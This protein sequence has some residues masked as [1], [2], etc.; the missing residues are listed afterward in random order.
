[1]RWLIACV[2]LI[3]SAGALA[4]GPVYG[5]LQVGMAGVRHSD[6]DF[7]PSFA[8]GSLGAFVIPNIGVELFGDASIASAEDG[9][10][11]MD[12]EQAYGVALRFQS[13]PKRGLS[14][15]V[16]VGAVNYTLNQQLDIEGS[17]A[18]SEEF[19]GA[20]FSIG[21]TQRLTRLPG[22]LLTA[23]YRH[24]NADGPLRVDAFMIGWRI[25]GR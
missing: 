24:Y 3:T 12:I 17:N 25:N 22:L 16:T 15:F 6:L 9:N 19:T 1:M 18:I 4:D 20:R 5:E 21:I 7:Y 23:E 8:S 2:L 11:D 10:F 14:G 13:P